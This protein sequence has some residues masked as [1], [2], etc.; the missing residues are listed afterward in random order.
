MNFET[1]LFPFL[2]FA[3]GIA[4][5][6][7]YD[8]LKKPEK[9]FQ[10]TTFYIGAIPTFSQTEQDKI[11]NNPEILPEIISFIETKLYL[12]NARAN[13]F[14]TDDGNIKSVEKI[15]TEKGE[16]YALGM[17]ANSLRSLLAKSKEKKKK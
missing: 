3:I 8:F 4:I 13:S 6:F 2:G 1:L 14:Y 16:I 10:K 11:T 17:V 15:Y 7:L 12:A 5:R 9:N